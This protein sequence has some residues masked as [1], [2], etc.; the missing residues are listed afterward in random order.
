[1]LSLVSLLLSFFLPVFHSCFFIFMDALSLIS[2]RDL[3]FC[4]HTKAYAS[5]LN[6]AAFQ[7]CTFANLYFFNLAFLQACSLPAMYSYKPLFLTTQTRSAK[8]KCIGDAHALYKPTVAL[9]PEEPSIL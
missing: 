5:K 3:K 6:F 8:I 1:M 9:K 7:S 4:A 2:G